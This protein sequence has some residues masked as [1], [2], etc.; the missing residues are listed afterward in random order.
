ME[1]WLVAGPARGGVGGV[2]R[3]RFSQN[4]RSAKTGLAPKRPRSSPPR[5]TRVSR[6]SVQSLDPG[7]T[8]G[9]ATK[10][11][12]T[13]LRAQAS[14][15]I[16]ESWCLGDSKKW[17]K[18]HVRR[19]LFGDG[20]CLHYHHLM[21][22]SLFPS[23]SSK[24]IQSTG[25]SLVSFETG[26]VIRPATVDEVIRATAQARLDGGYGLIAVRGHMGGPV[27]IQ[28]DCGAG[29]LAGR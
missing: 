1:K 3:I 13:S 29:H 28:R 27:F 14:G 23:L 7:A 12:L 10:M 5:S 11:W 19:F 26:M 2:A 4:G 25:Y 24:E 9:R 15:R 16:R 8:V 20:V 17:L 18:S 6:N 22:A 21:Q